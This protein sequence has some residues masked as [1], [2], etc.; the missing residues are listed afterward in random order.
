MSEPA[1]RVVSLVP[2][3]TEALASVRREAVVGATDWCTHP[4]DL[5]DTLEARVR[6]TK[7]PNLETIRALRPDVVIANHEENR[8]LDV[9][10]LRESGVTVHVTQI[11]TVPEA[12]ATF[13]ELFD[14]VLGWPRPDWLG[15][16][17]ALWCGELPEVTKTVAIPIWRDPWMVV[18]GSTFTSDLARRLGWDNAFKDHEDRYPNV[19]PEE[20]HGVDLVL[21]PDEPYVF[22]ESDGPEAFAST[23]TRLVSGRLLTWYG[24]SLLDARELTRPHP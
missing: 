18:G 9:R 10:R 16:A 19:Q 20:M 17:K 14:D 2:S 21:L 24:P 6:G 4:A 5:D 8:E 13:E 15:E 7:N 11:E 3:I 1:R 12:I 23:E 22:T